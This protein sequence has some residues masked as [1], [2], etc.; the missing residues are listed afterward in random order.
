MCSAHV[1]ALTHESQWWREVCAGLRSSPVTKWMYPQ[2]GK[3][4]PCTPETAAKRAGNGVV[5]F[6]VRLGSPAGEEGGQS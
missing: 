1:S 5:V 3:L 6:P 4:A 2:F